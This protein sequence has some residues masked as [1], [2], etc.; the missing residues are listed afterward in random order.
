MS[1]KY[2]LPIFL[3]L[4]LGFTG[5]IGNGDGNTQ[6][7]IPGQLSPQEIRNKSIQATQNITSYSL[8]MTMNMNMDV[9]SNTTNKTIGNQTPGKVNTSS[10]AYGSG[11]VNMTTRS[12]KIEMTQQIYIPNN[13]NTTQQ[14]ITTTNYLVNNSVYIYSE[15]LANLT[16]NN[17]TDSNG[18]IKMGIPTQFQNMWENQNQLRQQQ[19]FLNISEDVE[20]L[21][22]ET[23]DGKEAYILGITLDQQQLQRYLQEQM[24]GVSG[25]PG[26]GMINSGFLQIEDM[27]IK[28]WI[29]KKNYY[30]IKSQINMTSISDLSSLAQNIS[31]NQTNDNTDIGTFSIR[32]QIYMETTMTGFNEPVDI[33]LPKQARNAVD[34]TQL[35]SISEQQSVPG[36]SS[37]NTTK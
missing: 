26:G 11:K 30:P 4:I 36:Y 17:N 33:Q 31:Q 9:Q 37:Q 22:N 18:W 3:V 16:T 13:T 5:C 27:S 34:I 20:L 1:K 23:V 8:N 14:N 15:Q 28:Q 21:G 24:S 19:M 32:S 25:L 29:S 2:L 35:Q 6:T 12:M 10:S 7:P